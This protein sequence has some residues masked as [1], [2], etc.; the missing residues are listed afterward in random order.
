[1]KWYVKITV[2]AMGSTKDLFF[3]SL[4]SAWQYCKVCIDNDVPCNV[5][6]V[7]GIA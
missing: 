2:T 6:M 1:M 4:Y 3:V 7:R 5:T